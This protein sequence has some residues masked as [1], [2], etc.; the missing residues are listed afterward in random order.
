VW[1]EQRD[2]A[3]RLVADGR[4]TEASIAAEVGI[5]TRTLE[6]WRT[7]PEFQER[8]ERYIQAAE[9]KARECAIARKMARVAALQERWQALQQIR[10]ERGQAL[11]GQGIPGGE[12]GDLVRSVKTIGQGERAQVV[13]EYELDA[14][15]L[16]ELRAHEEQAARE[17]GQWNDQ[18]AEE[19]TA[20]PTALAQVLITSREDAVAYMAKLNATPDALIGRAAPPTP[21]AL[22]RSFKDALAVAEGTEGGEQGFGGDGDGI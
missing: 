20:A 1:T 9:V 7:Q 16:R 19:A 11:A 17:L 5:S 4:K 3:A 21:A 12:T 8:V 6:R 15:L 22:P 10:A 14:A 18:R 2:K 13:T